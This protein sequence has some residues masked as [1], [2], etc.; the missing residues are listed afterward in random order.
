MKRILL[1]QPSRDR[2][3][4]DLRQGPLR[5]HAPARRRPHRRSDPARAPARLR[6]GVVGRTRSTRPSGCCARR[7][8]ASSSRSPAPR[9]SSRRTRSAKLVRVGPESHEAVLPEEVSGALDAYRLPLSS[10]A[11]RRGR[12]RARRRAA[13]GARADRRPLGQVGAPQRRPRSS[14]SRATRQ[15]ASAERVVLIW[16]G[17]GGRGGAT[18]RKLAEKLGLAERR[19]A[20]RSTFPRRRTAAASP[21][22][23]RPAAT[24][25][26]KRADSIGLLIV[27][28]DEA[29]DDRTSAR[30]PSSAE[31]MIVISMFH[32]LAAGW[33]DLV[34]PGTS[35]LE[36]DGT[37]VNLEGRLQ[38]L[39]RTVEP[40]CP[41]ELEWISQLAARFGVDVAPYAAGVFARGLG[42]RLRR[43]VVR[44][45]RRARAAAR[46]SRR[47]G[48]RRARGPARAAAE[49]EARRDPARRVQAA[50][51]RRRRRARHGAAVPAAAG[52]GRALGRRR[53]PAQD[54][55]R[56]PRHRR[57]ERQRDH[58]AGPRQP[59]PARG[60][61]ARRARA[62]G[63]L[64]RRSWR[65]RRRRCPQDGWCWL[66]TSR[67]GSRSSRRWSSSTSCSASSPT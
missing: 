21:T 43:P 27:S 56:R 47:A 38:R 22:P 19:A 33:A 64:R 20:A 45:G 30:S 24:R 8:A 32:G 4:L 58:A 67:G 14:P 29:A 53:P 5:V 61:R 52:R 13:R 12:R 2:R 34:L 63:G 9:R 48:A 6:A 59:P 41:D 65:S 57:L 37:Y 17:P 40:P 35:Y 3:G 15:S 44:R 18:S 66:P 39:R 31:A 50:L 10:I 36:R 25:R 11:R 62:R 54:R 16:S 51:L 60:R 23:G 28:G 42:A 26:P 46:L 7:T 1:A 55:D 49:G